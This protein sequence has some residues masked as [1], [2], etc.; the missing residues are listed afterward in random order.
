MATSVRASRVIQATPFFYG[1]VVLLAGTLGIVMMGPSQTFTVGLFVESF[2]QD[3][4]LTRS[5]F[6]LLYGLATLAASLMLPITGRFVDR[7]GP[8][9][10]MVT[11]TLAFGVACLA[12]AWVQGALSLFIVL[13]LLRFLGFGSMQLVSNNAIAQ[14]FIR[15]RGFVMGLSGQALAVS[16]LLFP[17]L[18]QFLI[19]QFG[20]R[21]AWVAFG[22][23]AWVIMLPVSWLFYRD[24][25][26]SYGLQPDGDHVEPS[27]ATRLVN[28]EDW[29]LAEARRTGVFWLF[30][31]SLAALTMIMAGLVFHQSSLFA[32]RG[33]ARETAIHAFQVSALGSIV[34]NLATGQLLDKISARLLLAAMAVL[35]AAAMLM[36]LVM[37]TPWQAVAYAALMGLATGSYRVMDSTVWAKYFG[38]LHL[39]KIRGATMIG[40]LGGTAFGAY[41][42]GL[43]YDV[44]GSYAPALLSL[45][46]LPL[47]ITL[48][49]LFVQ[50]PG[51]RR[52]ADR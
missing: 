11:V 50:R 29:T 23:L 38:R 46:V 7:R 24:R 15:R 21:G 42:L 12:M 52:A 40:T 30:A 18:A 22:L 19:D 3:F 51:A 8:R 20:W 25:P 47:G 45:L 27:Q 35:L 41:P 5:G 14:W 13:L 49:A 33:L 10:A 26:E 36:V 2:E 6:S 28:H 4:G 17:A 37:I 32:E 9:R 44:T 48:A 16:L 39:G 31:V 1:W 43:S 34:G